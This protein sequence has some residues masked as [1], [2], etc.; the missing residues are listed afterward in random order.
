MSMSVYRALNQFQ[1]KL[2]DTVTIHNTHMSLYKLMAILVYMCS[3]L[4]STTTMFGD[5]IHCMVPQPVPEKMFTSYC[6]MEATY[7]LPSSPGPSVAPAGSANKSTV[8]HSYYQWVWLLLAIQSLLTYLPCCT[9]EYLEGG[10][11]ARLL[12]N[13][14]P[15]L[16]GKFLSRQ[17]GWYSNQAASFLLCQLSCL[18]VSM[19]QVFLMDQFLGGKVVF[20]ITSWPPPVFPMVT[21]C[22]MSYMGPSASV[23]NY[24]GMCTLSYNLLYEKIYMVL[25]PCYLLLTLV[26]TIHCLLQLLILLIPNLRL[27]LLKVKATD[28]LNDLLAM[29]I[30]FC[31]YGDFVLF[32]L[33][34]AN[35]GSPQFSQMI[36]VLV[37]NLSNQLPGRQA[38]TLSGGKRPEGEG[39]AGTSSGDK[40]P[41]GKVQGGT[42]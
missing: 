10:K 20:S 22:S 37:D 5:P 25:I 1:L 8:H 31:S 26:S 12:T 7:S 2:V 30:R 4:A 35:L 19:V 9:W 33:L 15:V 13:T 14:D 40:R 3:I 32:M 16:I 17:P 6:Y 38:G 21:K 28:L 36:Q 41:E 27:Q 29:K 18:F 11:L 24:S 34:S 42:R 23:T 39:Q